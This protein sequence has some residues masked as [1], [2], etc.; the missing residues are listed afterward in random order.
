MTPAATTLPTVL[1]PSR[2][3]VGRVYARALAGLLTDEPAAR[4]AAAQ[5]THIAE[6]V[7]TIDGG[8]ELLTTAAT[9]AEKR[10]DL[11]QRIFAGRVAP[12]VEAML[13][14]LAR[15]GRL[16]CLDALAEQF[17]K[18]LDARAGRTEVLVRTAVAL[19]DEQ[20]NRIS[21]TLAEA[22]GI[23]P[24]LREIVDPDVLAGLVVQIGDDVYDA[25]A[26]GE[27]Q[28]MAERMAS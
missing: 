17:E 14:V 3:G 27:I 26:A 10:A 16:D 24:V 23:I 5:L 11:V 28:R 22:R 21:E 18:L 19:T 1:D 20:R 13:D 2:I 25:S 7:R 12:W 9:T 15:N 6:I 4:Q 8:R